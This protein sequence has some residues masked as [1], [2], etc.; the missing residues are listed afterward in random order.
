MRVI[1]FIFSKKANEEQNLVL[2]L[3][4]QL[5]K[6]KK[7]VVT[8]TKNKKCFSRSKNRFS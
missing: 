1:R 3:V 2:V 8:K 7:R 5:N 6:K 4:S